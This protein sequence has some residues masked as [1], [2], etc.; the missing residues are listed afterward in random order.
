MP[1][2]TGIPSRMSTV[3]I[4]SHASISMGITRFDAAEYSLPQKEKLKGVINIAAIVAMA[5][6]VIERA[7]FPFASDEMKFDMLPPGQ[8]ATSIIP[9]AT[10]GVG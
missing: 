3:L 4:I 8:A 10:L 6:K 2:T 1:R 7:T 9:I 5:V